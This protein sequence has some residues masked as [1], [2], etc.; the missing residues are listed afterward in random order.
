MPYKGAKHSQGKEIF[1]AELLLLYE[2]IEWAHFWH[3]LPQAARSLKLKV[4]VGRFS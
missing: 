4:L 1:F 2:Y 3:T